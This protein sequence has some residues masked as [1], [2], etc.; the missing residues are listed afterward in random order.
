MLKWALKSIQDITYSKIIFIA[1]KDHD[2]KYG[3]SD[4]IRDLVD[5]PIVILIDKVTEGQLCTVLC[6]REYLKNQ[7]DLMIIPSDTLVISDLGKAI[8]E[9][10]SDCKGIISVAKLPGKQWSF[11]KT[12]ESG[13]VVE[14]AEKIRISDLASTGLYYF[15]NSAEFVKNADEIINNREKTQNEY[16]IIPVY[17]RMINQG[18][19][20]IIFHAKEMWDLGTPEAKL[21]FEN[22]LKFA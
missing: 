14:V 11:A 22:H 16:Y 4:L 10:S 19:K 12:N 8:E 3:I 5:N 7:E 2:R 18:K 20:I 13:D 21:E 1:L 17:Q 6:A 9:K 15:D